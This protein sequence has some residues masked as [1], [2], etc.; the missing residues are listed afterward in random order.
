M[1]SEVENRMFEVFWKTIADL[2]T[3]NNVSEFFRELLTPTE[4]IMLA[5]RLGI[6]I[7]LMKKYS[8]EEIVD[9]MKVSPV[10]IGIVS[11]WM[12]TKGTAFKKAINKIILQERHEQFWDNLEQFLSDIIPP[13]RGTNWSI[14]RK[15]QID[16]F[17]QRR[18]KRSIL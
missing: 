6:A 15:D 17:R 8:Y 2:Q 1:S 4:Q 13:R 11:R 10:T 16:R 5:K 18:L 9:L 3:A 7:L 14:A 12:K